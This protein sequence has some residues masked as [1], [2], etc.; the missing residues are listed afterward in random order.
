MNSRRRA[1]A[2]RDPNKPNLPRLLDPAQFAS[3]D[4]CDEALR[5]GLSY[6]NVELSAGLTLRNV[7]LR[8]SRFTGTRWPNS[9]FEHLAIADVSAFGCDLSNLSMTNSSLLRMEIVQSRI[10]GLRVSES[11]MREMTI[12]DCRGHFASFRFCRLHNIRFIDCSLTGASFEYSNL[13]NVEFIGCELDG[14]QFSGA[15]VSSARFR[16]CVLSGIGGVGGLS[17]SIVGESDLSGLAVSLAIAAG[18]VVDPAY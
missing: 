6:E 5:E 15:K 10:S 4:F 11:S 1:P 13:E 16:D 17:G 12:R 8:R 14:A 18:I 2:W 9:G 7:E 3:S